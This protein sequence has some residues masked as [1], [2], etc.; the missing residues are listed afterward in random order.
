VNDRNK[1]ESTAK[2]TALQREFDATRAALRDASESIT[3]LVMEL[4]SGLDAVLSKK[5]C[6]ALERWVAG[7]HAAILMSLPSEKR[8]ASK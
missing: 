5:N 4:P 3:R 1:D 8:N 2:L 7:K 6:A